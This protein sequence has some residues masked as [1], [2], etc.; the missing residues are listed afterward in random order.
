MIS[1]SWRGSWIFGPAKKTEG[2]NI[3]RVSLTPSWKWPDGISKLPLQEGEILKQ[4]SLPRE[5][6]RLF[7]YSEAEVA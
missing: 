5:V 6:G 3:V 1:P 2:V 7:R 4:K